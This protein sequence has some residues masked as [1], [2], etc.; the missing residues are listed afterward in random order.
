[1]IIKLTTLNRLSRKADKSVSITFTTAMEQTSEEYLNLDRLFQKDCILAIKEGDSQF[2]DVELNDLDSID[3]DIYDNK[4][5]QSQRIRN[6]LWKIQEQELKREPTHEEFKE[7]YRIKTEQLIEH[8]KNK[9][10]LNI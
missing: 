6:V 7:Y 4:K 3:L 2:K 8:F 9:L 1:M 5:S 10:L